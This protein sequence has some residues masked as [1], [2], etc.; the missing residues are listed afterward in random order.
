[1]SYSLAKL[2]IVSSAI[3]SA[4]L[5]MLSLPAAEVTVAVVISEIAVKLTSADFSAVPLFR[6]CSNYC[7]ATSMVM[8]CMTDHQALFQ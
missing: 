2:A 3:Y 1:M 8:T 6:G 4:Q 7:G 5:L